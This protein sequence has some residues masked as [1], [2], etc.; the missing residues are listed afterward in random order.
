MTPPLAR[1]GLLLAGGRGTRLLALTGGGNKHL[2]SIH[3]RALVE[4]P[5]GLLLRAG[6]R[7]LLIVADPAS[8]PALSALLGD[9]R[10]LG[11]AITYTAQPRPEG[12]AQVF[13]L[14]AAAGFLRPGQPSVLALGDNLFLGPDTTL[15]AA[16]TGANDHPGATVFP[17][18]VPDA[19]PYGVVTLDAAGH[20][21]A[22]IEKPAAPAAGLA[23][24]GLYFYDGDVLGHAAQ[25]QPS[26]RGELEITDLNRAYL[27]AGRLRLAALPATVTW[28]DAGTPSRV[29]EA[30]RL[31][32]AQPAPWPE[33]I[34]WRRGWIDVAC[35]R[36]RIAEL[37]ATSRA[38]Q[39]RSLLL[40]NA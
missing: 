19:S 36:A 25:L 39:L 26:A 29:A 34:A 40:A 3:D 32:A 1:K 13:S 9:G 4:F 27:A 10:H 12:V 14:A 21:V 30:A 16:L 20:P 5:L 35:L 8:L 23:V 24:P 7:E 33:E 38:A 37:G 15:D 17:V 28:I 2:L 22:L 18:R 6:C 11:V 31:A